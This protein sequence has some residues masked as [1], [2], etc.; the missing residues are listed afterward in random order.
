MFKN[1]RLLKY[2]RVILKLSGESLINLKNKNNIDSFFLNFLSQEIKK[3]VD[4]NV[5]L[6]IVIGA[7]NLFRGQQLQKIGFNRVIA[8]QIGILSTIING[9]AINNFMNQMHIK[10]LLM[11]SIPLNGICE[12]YNWN[13]A[14][15]FLS[16][17]NV[18]IFSAGIGNPFFTT[19]S[20]ACL[21][22]IEIKADIVLK[23]T[24]VDGVYTSDPKKNLEAKLYSQLSYKT[25]LKKELK[26]MDLSAFI[27]ARD[28]NLPI[29]IF[30]IRKPNSLLRIVQGLNEGTLIH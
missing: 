17:K 20:A 25:V 23:G 27:L 28:Y 8:D 6:G 24:Q 5:E 15:K 9:L 1:N 12:T 30:N 14:I 21:R 19:D 13:R 26:V 3:I 22:A 2:K 4:L 10:T 11:S 18:I 29:R 7:G 16:Q